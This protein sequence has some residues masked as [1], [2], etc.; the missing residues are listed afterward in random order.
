MNNTEV[1]PGRQDVQRAAPG[2]LIGIARRPERYAPMEELELG[3]ITVDRG[4]SGDHKGPKFPKR[5][6]TILA[7][8]GWR[9]ALGQL[10]EGGDPIN[11]PWTTRRANLLVEG[12]RLP[13]ARG[14]IIRVGPAEFEVMYPAQPCARMDKAHMGL[15]KALHPDWRGGVACAVRRG[16]LVR[17]HDEVEIVFSPPE[18]PRRKLP[19]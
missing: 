11:L 14:G 18:K 6:I 15:L 4:L 16:G 9:Q 19:G 8:E 1:F 5:R 13:R 10:A 17:L 12:V 3:E 7:I 2:A